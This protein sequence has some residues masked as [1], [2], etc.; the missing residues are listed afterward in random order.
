M[1]TYVTPAGLKR[2]TL[3]EITQSTE[4]KQPTVTRFI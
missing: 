3:Q 2:K 1:G 4:K